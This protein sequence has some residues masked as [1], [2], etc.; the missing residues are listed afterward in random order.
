MD[1]K[2]EFPD[3]YA[4]KQIKKL[5]Q[6]DN[7]LKINLDKMNDFKSDPNITIGGTFDLKVFNKKMDQIKKI[8]DRR[9]EIRDQIKL[10]KLSFKP[11]DYN[12]M[13]IGEFKQ[14]LIFDTICMIK[15]FQDPIKPF[16][17]SKFITIINKKYRK[18]TIFVILLI[19]FSISYFLIKILD[20]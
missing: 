12:R 8:R 6:E 11:L 7:L 10:L 20:V 16:T 5:S 19:I 14:G 15:E 9:N 17:W 3:I 2:Y 1:K 4:Q 18:I 13:T